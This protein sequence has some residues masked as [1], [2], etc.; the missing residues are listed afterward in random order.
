MLIAFGVL[1]MGPID[2]L[3][4][5]LLIGQ[6]ARMRDYVVI[7]STLGGIATFGIQGFI[8]GPVVAAT[9]FAVLDIF[10]LA[11]KEIAP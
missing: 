2:N 3:L 4:R 5:P 11:G 9:F 8:I 6:P 1:I 10:A 7:I